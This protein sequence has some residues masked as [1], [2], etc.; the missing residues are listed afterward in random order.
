MLKTL[1]CSNV[2]VVMYN[3]IKYSDNY[4]KKNNKIT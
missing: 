3:L 4:I 1:Q 2:Y